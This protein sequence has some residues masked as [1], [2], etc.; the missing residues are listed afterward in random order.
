MGLSV[1]KTPQSLVVR[2]V[3]FSIAVLIGFA[4]IAGCAT[5]SASTSRPYDNHAGHN[6]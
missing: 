6:H 1:R 4:T 5:D 2:L 3:A